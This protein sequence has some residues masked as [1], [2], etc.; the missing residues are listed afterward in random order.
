MGR[1]SGRRVLITGA[2]DSIG[3]AGAKR[4]VEEGGAVA[5]TTNSR[6]N[7]ER[8]R[9]DLPPAAIILDNGAANDGAAEPL[10]QRAKQL[11]AFDGFW[12]NA[13]SG[14]VASTDEIDE[15]FFDRMIDAN[16]RRPACSWRGSRTC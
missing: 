12:L 10:A 9:R 16:V 14:P 3:L 15:E 11:G 4:I 1:F 8:A 5:V 7:F 6:E 2:T 13:G